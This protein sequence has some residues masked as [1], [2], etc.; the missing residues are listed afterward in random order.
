MNQLTPANEPG[1]L[2]ALASYAILDTLPEI[3]FAE[4]TE[5]AAQI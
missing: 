4:S 2:D 1:R 3:G 5:L